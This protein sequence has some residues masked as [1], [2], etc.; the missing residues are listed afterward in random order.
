MHDINNTQIRL[1]F[2]S[3]RIW[4]MAST[5]TILHVCFFNTYSCSFYISNQGKPITS[6]QN[7]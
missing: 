6:E 4:F 1:W 5:E 3:D 2:L 7:L